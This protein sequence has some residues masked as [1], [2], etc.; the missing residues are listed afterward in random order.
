[1]EEK[2]GKKGV[3]FPHPHLFPSTSNVAP[4]IGHREKR[5]ERS[6][7]GPFANQQY[8]PWDGAERKRPILSLANMSHIHFFYFKE[9]VS[10]PNS[11]LFPFID[12]ESYYTVDTHLYSKLCYQLFGDS[13]SKIFTEKYLGH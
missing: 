5:E 4:S 6:L 2:E 7:Q 10:L 12:K 13:R 9:K 8:F 3:L 1:M 11:Y